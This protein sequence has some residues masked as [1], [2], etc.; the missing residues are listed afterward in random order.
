M[1][2]ALPKQDMQIGTLQLSFLFFLNDT[3]FCIFVNAEFKQCDI[4]MNNLTASRLM[5]STADFCK[6][7]STT[8]LPL[9][10]LPFSAIFKSQIKKV[11]SMNAGGNVWL[12]FFSKYV[13]FFC[14][15]CVGTILSKLQAG[16]IYTDDGQM[17]L[18]FFRL[19]FCHNLF[20]RRHRFDWW[21]PSDWLRPYLNTSVEPPP[22]PS[23]LHCVTPHSFRSR[24][25]AMNG[26]KGYPLFHI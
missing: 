11:L 22:S 19:Q 16:G 2:F 10:S 8:T 26:L 6:G 25:R 1:P 13:T 15:K 9:I 21:A 17:M 18:M 7:W 20:T 23:F 5:A 3:E 14:P 24:P 4:I 12:H